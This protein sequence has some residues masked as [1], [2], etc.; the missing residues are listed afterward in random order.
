MASFEGSGADSPKAPMTPDAMISPCGATFPDQRQQGDQTNVTSS[1]GAATAVDATIAGAE[2]G[3]GPGPPVDGQPP[4]QS[5]TTQ[6]GGCEE[7]MQ[8]LSPRARG[9]APTQEFDGATTLLL[10]TAGGEPPEEGKKELGW[11]TAMFLLAQWHPPQHLL[12]LLQLRCL[13]EAF[14]WCMLTW[15]MAPAANMSGAGVVRNWNAPPKFHSKAS[16]ATELDGSTCFKVISAFVVLAIAGCTST[17]FNNEAAYF[18]ARTAEEDVGPPALPHFGG[19]SHTAALVHALQEQR[20]LSASRVPVGSV[21]GRFLGAG[22]TEGQ[23]GEHFFGPARSHSARVDVAR[24]RSISSGSPSTAVGGHLR[25]QGGSGSGQRETDGSRLGH[26]KSRQAPQRVVASSSWIDEPRDWGGRGSGCQEH[27]HLENFDEAER[28]WPYRGPRSMSVNSQCRAMPQSGRGT[29]I[30]AASPRVATAR[31][32]TPAGTCQ[33]ALGEGYAK[34]LSPEVCREAGDSFRN[35]PFVAGRCQLPSGEGYPRRHREDAEMSGYHVPTARS[36]QLASGECYGRSL[37]PARH[38]ADES[39]RY[40]APAAGAVQVGLGEGHGR[41]LPPESHRRDERLGHPT[42]AEGSFHLGSGEVHERMLSPPSNREDK[43]PGYPRPQDESRQLDCGEGYARRMPSGAQREDEIFGYPTPSYGSHHV[44]VGET[45]ASRPVLDPQKREAGV[46]HL[47]KLQLEERYP[48]GARRSLSEAPREVHDATHRLGA[49]D[50]R[51]QRDGRLDVGRPCGEHSSAQASPQ[52]TSRRAPSHDHD[53][54]S[55][56][57]AGPEEAELELE[58][59]RLSAKIEQ[60]QL[61]R[62][63]DEDLRNNT[64]AE[65]YLRSHNYGVAAPPTPALLVS[66]VLHLPAL[67][68]ALPH[69]VGLEPDK[70]RREPDSLHRL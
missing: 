44:V 69:R 26:A 53:S 31:L 43:R 4:V 60:M 12:Q 30:R 3:G 23:L 6:V 62:A 27:R 54:I 47:S 36:Q 61:D 39:L 7:G 49:D 52:A 10:E 70:E 17:S 11:L 41:P 48:K 42:P 46:Q 16:T 15:W 14:A 38:R 20:R 33:M 25:S 8:F 21:A 9:G 64:E 67:V 1:P 19:G 34:R 18:S 5:P 63:D 50:A 66:E 51:I 2:A 28:E 24:V 45:Y 37:S 29:R 40:Q 65:S 56:T 13:Q 68:L 58:I 55:F 22:Q 59:R 35:P 57:F 32:R